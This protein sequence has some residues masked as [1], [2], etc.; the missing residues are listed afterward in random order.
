MGFGGDFAAVGVGDPLANAEAQADAFE[1]AA[2][3]GAAPVKALEDVREF[4]GGNA[5]APAVDLEKSVAVSRFEGVVDE[6]VVAVIL[7]RVVR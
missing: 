3:G 5:A 6:A 1:V 7:D 4:V 2:A